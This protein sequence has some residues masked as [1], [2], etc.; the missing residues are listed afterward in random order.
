MT[1][2][3]MTAED[4]VRPAAGGFAVTPDDNTDLSQPI[5]GITIGTSAGVVVYINW[6]GVTCTTG[7]LPIGTYGLFATRILSTGTTATGITGWY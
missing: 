1:G 3:N 4:S 2:P 5:R 7:S 6:D